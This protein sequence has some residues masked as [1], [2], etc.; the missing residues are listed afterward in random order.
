MRTFDVDVY[1][2]ISEV[3][4]SGVRIFQHKGDSTWNVEDP[5]GGGYWEYDNLAV[6]VDKA[7]D[8]S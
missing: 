8:L 3:N 4:V 1:N 7:Y 2:G 5:L 6:A